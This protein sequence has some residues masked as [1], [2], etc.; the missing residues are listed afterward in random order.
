[1]NKITVVGLGYV[2][3]ATTLLLARR[4]NVVGIDIDEKKLELL[5]KRISP[6]KEPELQEVLESTTAGFSNNLELCK[7]SQYI[8]IALPTNFDDRTQEFD[9]SIIESVV[10][11]V[12]EINPVAVIVIKSTIPVGFIDYLSNKFLSATFAFMP[13]FLREGSSYMDS[14]YPTR[15]IAGAYSLSVGQNL[16]ELYQQ[17]SVFAKSYIMQP[18]EAEAVKLFANTYLAMRVAFFNELDTFAMVNELNSKAIINGICSDTRIGEFY[19]NPSFGYGGYCLPKDTKQ[20]RTNFTN[21]GSPQTVID[22][23]IKS[24]EERKK[25]IAREVYKL[26]KF[27]VGVYKLAMKSGSDNHRQSAIMD[28][29]Q[30]LPD[31]NC[32]IYDDSVTADKI[33]GY[34]VYKDLNAFCK[35]IKLILTNRVDDTIRKYAQKYNLEI[36]T[37][38]RLGGN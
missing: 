2:G 16:I 14:M 30:M 24:N 35:D 13:E 21:S 27:P 10:D 7:G 12:L 9:T 38:D 33:N 20:L 3:L 25:F 34:K 37:C 11:K 17:V 15:V 8:F 6:I 31:T 4:N 22:A 29:I 28:I 32:Y 5:K 18:K 36:F 23:V 1:M 19:N 26:N